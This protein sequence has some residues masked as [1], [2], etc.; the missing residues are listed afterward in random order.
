M[1]AFSSELIGVSTYID[2]IQEPTIYKYFERLNRGEFTAVAE[3]FVEQGCL[4][5]P[6]EKMIQ[7]RNIIAKYLEKEASGMSFCP[8]HGAILQSDHQH[9]QY[10]IYGRVKTNY[11][12]VKV[13]WLIQLN[14]ASEI[15]V[16]E[17]KLLA[18]LKELSNFDNPSYIAAPAT[19]R[20]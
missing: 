17:V 12:T 11:F 2:G 3:L 10:Q 7:G 16:V 6:F 15:M 20:T 5:P 9:I 8:E 1:K 13:S 4:I 18:S 14:Q 19:D